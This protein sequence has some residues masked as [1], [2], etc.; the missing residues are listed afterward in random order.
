M[1]R[2]IFRMLAYRAALRFLGRYLGP[3]SAQHVRR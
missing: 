1:F 2:F 3:R